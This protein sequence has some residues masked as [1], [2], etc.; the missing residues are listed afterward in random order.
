[1]IR[2]FY[3]EDPNPATGMQDKVTGLRDYD[4]SWIIN[5]IASTVTVGTHF[6]DKPGKHI[7]TVLKRGSK[8]DV[9]SAAGSNM[10][11]FPTLG[12]A[13]HYLICW[14]RHAS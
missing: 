8:W 3:S 2:R 9:R 14:N 4:G 12:S 10:L 5:E 7:G 13:V 11:D 6:Y 1:M